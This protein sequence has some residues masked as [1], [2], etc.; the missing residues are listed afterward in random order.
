MT[1]LKSPIV[2]DS[3]EDWPPFE[4]LDLSP[5]YTET[6]GP[7]LPA[8]TAIDFWDGGNK[9]GHSPSVGVGPP[10]ALHRCVRTTTSIPHPTVAE[11]QCRPAILEAVFGCSQLQRL[12]L[13]FDRPPQ[14]KKSAV[15]SAEEIVGENAEMDE[16]MTGCND[17]AE[18]EAKE[19]K[20]AVSVVA[21]P[22]RLLGPAVQRLPPF[23]HLRD[24][25][26]RGLRLRDEG[27]AA[28]AKSSHVQS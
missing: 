2:C 9:R 26:L 3:D 23:I 11:F 18:V 22:I 21:S 19:E 15:E 24:L 6:G 8:L 17:R 4:A 7:R 5:L 12:S 20:R 28:G 13:T 27:S 1:S 10:A 25:H 16:G 14:P